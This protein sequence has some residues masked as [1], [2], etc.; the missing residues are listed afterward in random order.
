L[1]LTA[2]LCAFV[3]QSQ[4]TWLCSASDRWR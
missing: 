1:R 4:G 3:T 2:D